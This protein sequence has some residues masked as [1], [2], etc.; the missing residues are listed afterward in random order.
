MS[1]A[2]IRPSGPV[3]LTDARSMPRSRAMRRA[4][5]DALIL[6]PSRRGS[7]AG[8]GPG[9]GACAA[10]GS[11]FGSSLGAS[12]ALSTLPFPDT[13]GTASPFSPM[14]AI[15]VP[16]GTSPSETAILSRTPAA[17]ASTSCV[18]LSVSSS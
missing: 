2:M 3:P 16:T 10:S 15:V 12:A 1:S 18:T 5:G 14:N 4:S 11:G 13:S 7:A 9:S 8:S 17:S 6:S